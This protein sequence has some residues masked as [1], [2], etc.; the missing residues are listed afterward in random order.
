MIFITKKNDPANGIMIAKIKGERI[1]ENLR[2]EDEEVDGE[3]IK[4]LKKTDD[5]ES[6]K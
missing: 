4:E 5:Y 1:I 2:V 6:R 3:K